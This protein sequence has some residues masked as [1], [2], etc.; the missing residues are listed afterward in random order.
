[1]NEDNDIQRSSSIRVIAAA[2]L[3]GAFIAA[4]IA[5]IRCYRNVGKSMLHTKKRGC[6]ADDELLAECG[7]RES[8]SLETTPTTS[9]GPESS[10]IFNSSTDMHHD[11]RQHGHNCRFPSNLQASSEISPGK[12]N[13][14]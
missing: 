1:M 10:I 3:G 8:P 12:R 14:N 4:A 6:H 13:S 2:G 11:Y 9:L 5:M 7:F